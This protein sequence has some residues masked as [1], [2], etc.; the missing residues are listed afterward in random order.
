MGFGKGFLI[1]AIATGAYFLLN[2]PQD[3]KT[4]RQ[5][6]KNYGHKVIGNVTQVYN[7]ANDLTHSFQELTE[8]G[9]P[10]LTK[11]IKEITTSLK[12]FEEETRPR[13]RRTQEKLEQLNTHLKEF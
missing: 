8:V 10:L 9:L 4:T 7:D 5:Q 3:G 11:T 2:T 13:V 6:L 1:G 12:H